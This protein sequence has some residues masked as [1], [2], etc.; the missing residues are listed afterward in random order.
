MRAHYPCFDLLFVDKVRFEG[1]ETIEL[2]L[3]WNESGAHELENLHL[4]VFVVFELLNEI[5]FVDKVLNQLMEARK[6]LI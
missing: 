4:L 1:H 2:I 5:L 3:F 6:F